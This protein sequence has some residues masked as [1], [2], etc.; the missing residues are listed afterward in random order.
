MALPLVVEILAEVLAFVRNICK[1]DTRGSVCLLDSLG[2][3]K[4]ARLSSL[5]L[6][7]VFIVA[8]AGQ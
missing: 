4:P 6:V 3:R 8:S 1:K 7:L 2:T 5:L